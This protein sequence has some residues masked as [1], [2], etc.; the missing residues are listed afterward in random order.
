MSSIKT[1]VSN[2]FHADADT[3]QS[4]VHHDHG[5]DADCDDSESSVD[6]SVPPRVPTPMLDPSTNMNPLQKDEHAEEEKAAQ[7]KNAPAPSDVS[8][9]TF[10]LLNSQTRLKISARNEVMSGPTLIIFFFS[11][12]IQRQMMQFIIALEKTAAASHYTRLNRFGS[13]S[14]IRD[15][16]AAQ[17]LVDG[18]RLLALPWHH[19]LDL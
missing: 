12:I 3:A 2:I 1:Q 15:N 5:D 19:V 16:V 18:V 11:E 7:K 10:Y 8:K 4:N 6:S 14:P 9:H 13:F 17:W